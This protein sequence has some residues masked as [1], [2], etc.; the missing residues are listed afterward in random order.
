MS[1]STMQCAFMK[2]LTNM[3]LFYC[4]VRLR[5]ITVQRVSYNTFR[6]ISILFLSDLVPFFL[7]LCY[8]IS[9]PLSLSVSLSLSLSLSCIFLTRILL[10][11]HVSFYIFLNISISYFCISMQGR[12]LTL[13][14]NA[15]IFC[16]GR[17]I[18]L[19][20]FE[21]MCLF[22]FLVAVI[23]TGRF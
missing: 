3:K 8:I 4:I 9:L 15:L 22:M 16:I 7:W 5:K 13:R 19:H 1:N 20:T 14:W 12:Y 6:W 23:A 2:K 17:T 11:Y 21:R 10:C 18:H